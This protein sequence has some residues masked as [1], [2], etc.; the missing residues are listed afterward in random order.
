MK[1]AVLPMKRTGWGRASGPGRGW[2]GGV[3]GGE[4]GEAA[5]LLTRN[6]EVRR[7]MRVLEHGW[8]A[9]PHPDIAEAYASVRP[10]DSVRDRL[11]R[12]RRLVEFRA[13]NPEGSLAIA[14]AAIDARDW[15]SARAALVPLVQ[16]DATERACLL[17]A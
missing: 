10:G 13:N 7:A 9:A 11:K 1:R 16:G 17:M 14:R 15:T 3:R 12:V 5:R 8:R 4:G 2:A 6:G